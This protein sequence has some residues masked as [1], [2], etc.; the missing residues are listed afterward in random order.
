MMG[1][2]SLFVLFNG[3]QHVSIC[4]YLS[5]STERFDEGTRD[6]RL[7]YGGWIEP[8]SPRSLSSLVAGMGFQ[9]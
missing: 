9:G 2:T 5:Y 3:A 7:Y 8:C 4:L 6:T 1:C